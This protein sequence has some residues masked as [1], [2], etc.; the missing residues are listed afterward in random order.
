MPD[1]LAIGSALILSFFNGN[2]DAVVRDN[3]IFPEQDRKRTTASPLSRKAAGVPA[4]EEFALK[5]DPGV[6]VVA[7]YAPPTKANRPLILYFHGQGGFREDHFKDLMEHGYGLLT[8]AYRGYNGSTGSPTEENVMRDAEAAYAEALER[9]YTRQRI[10]VMGESIGTGP[11]T[12]LAARHE[13]AAL[14]LDSP[15]DNTPLIGW[16]RS[17][18]PVGISDEY[19][20]DK[21]HADEAIKKVNAPVLM[22]VGCSDGA[23]PAERSFALYDLANNPKK[24]IVSAEADHIPLSKAGDALNQAMAW[25]DAPT[26]AAGRDSCPGLLEKLANFFGF[27]VTASPARDPSQ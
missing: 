7:W 20:K 24:M 3:F 4:A 27:A 1:A 13:E 17:Y 11:A 6:K 14:V 21:F 25:I 2:T 18:I 22:S 16:S 19:I 23:I 5:T 9:G 10:V 12:I 26:G 15:Y 8:F